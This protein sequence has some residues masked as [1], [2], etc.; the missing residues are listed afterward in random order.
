MNGSIYFRIGIIHLLFFLY[1]FS[2]AQQT[3]TYDDP[4]ASYR[5][6]VDLVEKKQY[7]AAQHLFGRL[8][9][10]LPAGE[11]VMRLEAG[12]YD[13]LCDYYL[14]HPQAKDKFEDFVRYYSD[15]SK[16]NLAFVYLGFIE[17]AARK[18]RYAQEYFEKVDPYRLNPELMPEYLYKLGYCYLQRE[19]LFKAKDA[20]FPI[21]NTASEYRDGANYYYAYIAYQEKDYQTALFHFEK[22]DLKSDFY[23]EVPFYQLQIYFIKNDFEQ[24]LTKGPALVEYY[25]KDKKKNSELARIVAEAYY[26]NKDYSKAIDYF[27][28]YLAGTQK[29]NSRDENYQLGYA[30]YK[31]AMYQKA[32]GY[33]EKAIKNK[34]EMSQNAYYHLAD[35]Y[36]QTG[37]TKFAQN[38]FYTAY[39]ISGN[40]DLRED[41]L[42]NYAKLTFELAYDPYNTSMAA[43][44][45]YINDFPNSERIDE[46][47]QYLINLFL[48]SKDYQA[49]INAIEK[50]KKKNRDMQSAYQ[51]IT[52][53]FGV[54][55]FNSGHYQPAIEN[56]RKALNNNINQEYTARSR[57]WIAESYFQTGEYT[58]AIDH[59]DSFESSSGSSKLD[60]FPLASYNLGYAYFKLKYYENAVEKFKKFVSRPG[61][62]GEPLL[63]DAYIRLGDCYFISKNFSQAVSYY[64]QAIS[65]SPRESDYALYQKAISEGARGRTDQKI[66]QLQNLVNLYPQSSYVDDATYEIAE[67]YLLRNDNQNAFKWFDEVIKQ[68]PNSSYFNRSLQ[69]IGLI[70]YNQNNFDNALEILKQLVIK[71]PNSTEARDAL[72]TIRNIYMDKNQVHKYYEFAESVPSAKISASEKDSITYI[73]AENFYLTNDCIS[74]IEA[75]DEYINKFENGAFVLNAYYYKAECEFNLGKT[76]EALQGYEFVNRFSKSR[77]SENSALRAAEIYLSNENYHKA[78]ENFSNLE[79]IADHSTNIITA[80]YGQMECHYKLNEYPEAIESSRKLRSLDR[81]SNEQL[82][83]SYYIA[84]KSELEMENLTKAKQELESTVELSQGAFG[85]EAKY[86]LATI[87]FKQGELK[88]VEDVVVELAGQYPSYEYWKAKGFLLLSDVY[89]SLGNI[90]QAKETL[91]SIIQYYPDKDLKEI[92]IEKLNDIEKKE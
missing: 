78:L 45:Q 18:Y 71:H 70:Y 50:L 16:T 36:L 76:N 90:F 15:H 73:A 39:Q 30:Y 28:K 65:R 24:I 79:L 26:Q 1:L 19:D 10:T 89:V 86:L 37:Q 77:F 29:V 69:K 14:N 75:F 13:G 3:K 38:A 17:Y 20:F 22:I 60:I 72:L 23:E 48:S 33:F 4:Q 88:K 49:S 57:F 85:A 2:H 44:N 92:A 35:C 8:I 82:I 68:Y 64:D 31:T 27:E 32:I 63:A 62:L 56:F 66:S 52:Y 58:R 55:L 61:I 80:I 6:A 74:A 67:T 43:L 34:D 83:K 21:L 5:Q 53:L 91:Q 9:S 41:A 12:F 11:S 81:I 87:A 47:Y 46:A 42:F 7:G 84:G 40:E 51:R 25:T 59:Y 54:Q